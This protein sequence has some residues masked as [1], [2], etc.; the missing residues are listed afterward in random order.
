MRNL[1]LA[2]VMAAGL[3]PVPVPA[4]D[5]G[6]GTGDAVDGW[7]GELEFS[8]LLKRGN[9]ESDS[10]VTKGDGEYEGHSWRH[11]AEF[12]AV[13]TTAENQTTGET[14]RVA[15][16]YYFSYKLDR[17]LGEKNY[18][19]NV[20]T[21]EKDLFSGYHYRI[22][23]ALGYGR[24]ILDTERHELSAEI[25]PGY[26]IRCLEPEDSYRNCENHE[27]SPILRMAGQYRWDISES[28]VF[29]ERISTEMSADQGSI[30]RAETSLSSQI[31]DT[32]T[33]R[34]S[35]LLKHSSEVPAGTENTD[36][37]VTVSLVVG[38]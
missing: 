4:A 28:A 25:G 2:A 36:H 23:Y 35:H 20:G 3:A 34:L 31:N 12:E 18:I 10:V 16:R 29:R 33:L 5:E 15:E 38:F 26:R 1:T 21:Y 11:T 6:D 17:K 7:S 8:Y 30:S 9:T 13:N 24:S 19:F 22:S 14:E 37:E 32:L 27:D